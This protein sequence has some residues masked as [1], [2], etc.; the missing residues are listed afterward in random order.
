MS[1]AN[2]LPPIIVDWIEKINDPKTPS[3]IRENYAQM[4]HIVQQHTSSALA[5]YNIEKTKLNHR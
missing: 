2:F 4:L 3:H 1:S 5:K